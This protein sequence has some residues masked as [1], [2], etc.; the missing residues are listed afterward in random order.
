[1]T[2][3]KIAFSFRVNPKNY[4]YHALL[5]LCCSLAV[6]FSLVVRDELGLSNELLTI[7]QKLEP[8]LIGREQTTSWPGTVLSEG[9]AELHRFEV[10]AYSINVLKNYSLSFF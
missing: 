2:S 9:S 6:Q 3:S 8:C 4:A 10:T 5:D 7:L 1:M